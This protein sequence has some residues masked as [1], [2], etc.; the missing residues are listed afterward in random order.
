[1]V[2]LIVEIVRSGVGRGLYGH[3]FSID[4]TQGVLEVPRAAKSC[5]HLLPLLQGRWAHNNLSHELL[6]NG[7][8]RVR[9][10]L[11]DAVGASAEVEGHTLISLACCHEA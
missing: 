7:L 3:M 2:A 6:D 10:H 5:C 1:M 9:N 4:G 8:A 11:R